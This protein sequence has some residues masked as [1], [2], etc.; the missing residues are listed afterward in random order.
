MPR[1]EFEF[2]DA[3]SRSRGKPS[4]TIDKYG[5]IMLNRAFRQMLKAEDLPVKLYVGYDR[6]YKRI[7]LAPAELMAD[8]TDK[9]PYTFDKDRGYASARAFLDY[10]G[11][12]YDRTYRYVLVDRVTGAYVFE[13]ED[14]WEGKPSE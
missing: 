2:F 8:K 11:I 3:R 13:R 10:Y 12:P 5:R 4:I 1:Q 7:A 6:N 14:K 9:E